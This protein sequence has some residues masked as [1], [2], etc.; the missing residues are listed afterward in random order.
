[1]SEL[2]CTSVYAWGIASSIPKI[3]SLE[4]LGAKV[5]KDV[6]TAIQAALGIN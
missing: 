4:I 2:I 1:M 5:Y 3:K 6:S